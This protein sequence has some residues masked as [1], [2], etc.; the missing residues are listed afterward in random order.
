M[1]GRTVKRM[2]KWLI[3]GVLA[4]GCGGS[5][6]A[7][8]RPVE[9]MTNTTVGTPTAPV[10][11]STETV[12]NSVPAPAAKAEPKTIDEGPGLVLPDDEPDAVGSKNLELPIR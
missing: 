1:E 7:A 12:A 11:K 5:Q 3:A 9:A 8:S 10:A 6:E 4:A 2:A